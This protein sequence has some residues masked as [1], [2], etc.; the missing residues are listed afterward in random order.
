MQ[1]RQIFH[2]AAEAGLSAAV[3]KIIHQIISFGATILL[4]R[5]LS[6]E[7]FGIYSILYAVIPMLNIVGS[8]GLHN[9][10]Q[11]FLPEYYAGSELRLAGKLAV[12]VF[13]IRFIATI[14][15]LAA[16][17]T[18]WDTLSGLVKIKE[19]K[20]YFAIFCVCIIAY[21]QWG[22]L[23]VTAESFFLH[24]IAF[25]I[26]IVV[27]A[28]RAAA[29]L[30]CFVKGYG[31]WEILVIDSVVYC[32]LMTAF[33][34]FYIRKVPRAEGERTQFGAT[35]KR[36]IL[37]YA[38]FNNFNSIGIR[39]MDSGVNYLIVA[40]FMSPTQVAIFAFCNQ[41][42]NRFARLN[43]VSHLT[44]VIRPA[45]FSLGLA[46]EE[47]RTVVMVRFLLKCIMWFFIPVFCFSILMGEAFIALVFGK[48]QEYSNIFAACVVVSVA[49]AIGFPISMSAQLR[50]R[51]DVILYSKIFALLSLAVSV[52]T[53]PL[54]GIWGAV[55]ALGMGHLFKNLFIG[56]FVRDL[57]PIRAVASAT[58]QVAIFWGAVTLLLYFALQP[59]AT[60]LDLA[61]GVAVFGAAGIVF[62]YAIV[63]L[64]DIE[65]RFVRT[66]AVKAKA[67]RFIPPRLRA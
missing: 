54:W 23:L 42:A 36:R 7:E 15:I 34:V 65:K 46:S 31:L 10:L 37:R 33:Y 3:L 39:F 62:A 21:Q 13:T 45:F 58:M 29:Y 66:M 48:Y 4:V 40:Y 17:F 25:T 30:V 64:D 11:R 24:K 12:R 56:W 18:Y 20:E 26:Q 50:E 9:V 47:E 57:L 60:P 51:V 5:A 27:V 55:V 67:E 63:T 16:I 43:P 19:Y 44:S 32:V 53:V 22:L 28:C 6:Q 35:D 8:L 49:N 2:R 38:F 61:I 14:V 59:T 41:L 52:L 1:S